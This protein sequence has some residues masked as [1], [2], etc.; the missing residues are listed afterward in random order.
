MLSKQQNTLQT[1]D[2]SLKTQKRQ[3]QKT[4]I[5]NPANKKTT[6]SNE[7]QKIV[8]GKN[9]GSFFFLSVLTEGLVT[10][11]LVVQSL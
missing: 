1:H 3:I 7:M 8:G 6:A 2:A 4:K 11:E 9:K 10:S 5:K